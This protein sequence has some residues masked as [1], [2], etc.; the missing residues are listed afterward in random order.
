[1]KINIAIDLISTKTGG[2]KSY[3]L[4]Q[5]R[6][7]VKYKSKYRIVCIVSDVDLKDRINNLGFK[8]MFLKSGGLISD[9]VN[10]LIYFNRIVKN[11]NID[12]IYYPNNFV[13]PLSKCKSVVLFQNVKVFGQGVD[14]SS[15]KEKIKY[16][17]IRLLA[18]YSIK[19]ANYKIYVSKEIKKISKDYKRSKVIYS[20]RPNWEISKNRVKENYLL[21]VS[22]ANSPHKNVNVLIDGFR[23]YN[24]LNPGINLKI[25]GGIDSKSER[26]IRYLGY[27]NNDELKNIYSKAL[28]FISS[29]IAEAFPLTPIEAMIKG[30]PCIL[31]DIPI[32]HEIYGNAAL[33]FDPYSPEDL[34]NKID[35][36]IKNKDL[37]NELIEKGFKKI[38]QYSW[39]SNVKQLATV[40]QKVINQ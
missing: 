34:S 9:I 11:N 22:T 12:L 31:S 6:E 1:M 29:S 19:Y 18:K 36:L 3:I 21:N 10:R 26:N 23:L 40:F 20:G 16:L 17:I 30:T 35:L 13:N 24:K 39:G 8:T 14:D 27:I 2:G 4:N 28:I 33:Y 15:M 37:Y 38:E 32:F 5:L 25:V 7:F